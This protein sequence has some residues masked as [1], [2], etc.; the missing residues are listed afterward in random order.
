[1]TTENTDPDSDFP[2][3]VPTEITFICL[4]LLMIGANLYVIVKCKVYQHF[5]KM[6]IMFCVTLLQL[7]RLVMYLWR[8]TTDKYSISGW[9]WYRLVTDSTNF[10]LGI[11]ALVLFIQWHQTYQVLCN[12]LNALL[13]MEKNWAQVVQI[14][15]LIAYTV[16]FI[17]DISVVMYDSL[18]SKGT[19]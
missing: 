5:N 12:P 10:L 4:L 1:M 14:V 17:F 18:S 7:V 2:G 3:R 15:L 13:T 8:A 6:V 19:Y 9:V 16:F 11:V